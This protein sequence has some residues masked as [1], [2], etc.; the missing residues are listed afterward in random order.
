MIFAVEKLCLNHIR[1][2]RIKVKVKEIKRAKATRII[3]SR[4]PEFLVR[5]NHWEDFIFFLLACFESGAQFGNFFPTVVVIAV[6]YVRS[7]SSALSQSA[8][9]SPQ[10]PSWAY[11]R[12]PSR[13]RS[14]IGGSHYSSGVGLR[15]SVEWL[16][17]PPSL[18]LLLTRRSLL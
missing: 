3:L 4:Q 5:R 16:K 17:S 6:W 2:N 9:T 7:P 15:P 10:Y 12:L 8:L 11:A 1:Y 14:S 18:D 13:S